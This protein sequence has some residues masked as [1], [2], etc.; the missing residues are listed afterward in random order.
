MILR[1]SYLLR[2]VV[3]L[4]C[5]NTKF[6]LVGS[7]FQ[8][9]LSHICQNFIFMWQRIQTVYLLIAAIVSILVVIWLPMYTNKD[10]VVMATENPFI[11]FLFGFSSGGLLANIFNYKKRSL[12]IVLNRIIMVAY[13]FAL[14]F[15][16]MDMISHGNVNDITIGATLF[17]PFFGILFVYLA[18]KGIKKD[19]K[20]IRSADRIR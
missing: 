11:F 12:Q 8:T 16:I 13:L 15:I 9:F 6:Y 10:V 7:L 3:I 1:Y 14:G 5:N 18:N 17:V 4:L 2:L 20:L 19:E